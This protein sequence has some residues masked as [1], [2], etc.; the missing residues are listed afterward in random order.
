MVY[1]WRRFFATPQ[2]HALPHLDDLADNWFRFGDHPRLCHRGVFHLDALHLEGPHHV[3][4]CLDDVVA[5]AEPEVTVPVG[6]QG[7]R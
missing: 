3:A 2:W 7:R 4:G 1:G 5:A 6:W